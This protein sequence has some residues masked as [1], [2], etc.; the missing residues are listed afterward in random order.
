MMKQVGRYYLVEREARE[1]KVTHPDNAEKMCRTVSR[2]QCFESS[3]SRYTKNILKSEQVFWVMC[4]LM[5]L[6]LIFKVI[7]LL[8]VSDR[9]NTYTGCP[10]IDGP[11]NCVELQVNKVPPIHDLFTDGVIIL[12]L[13]D[14]E[15][16]QRP[17]HQLV[18]L[19]SILLRC[20]DRPTRRSGFSCLFAC[21]SPGYLCCNQ[22]PF[23]I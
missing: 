7:L 2:S 17:T 5:R 13:K 15:T 21:G 20:C 14:S 19:S 9:Y 4:L 16:L 23:C 18:Q 22:E 10:K 11:F 12:H 1:R 3:T 8:F 6:C